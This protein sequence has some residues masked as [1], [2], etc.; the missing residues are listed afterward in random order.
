MMTPFGKPMNDGA[1]AFPIFC[2]CVCGSEDVCPVSVERSGFRG[3]DKC[4]RAMTRQ[5]EEESLQVVVLY[6]NSKNVHTKIFLLLF[7]YSCCGRI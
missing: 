1:Y 4:A 2:C 3:F 5:E 6:R 7:F